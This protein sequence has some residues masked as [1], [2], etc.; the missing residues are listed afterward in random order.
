MPET[1]QLHDLSTVRP[2]TKIKFALQ[3]NLSARKK[4][5]GTSDILHHEVKVV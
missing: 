4:I 3:H 1:G 5:T 2:A